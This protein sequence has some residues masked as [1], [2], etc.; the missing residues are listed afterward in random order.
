MCNT[1]ESEGKSEKRPD[2]GQNSNEEKIECDN[3]VIV[4]YYGP[5]ALL[6]GVTP[7]AKEEIERGFYNL[8]RY[9]VSIIEGAGT[10][11]SV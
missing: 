4:E 11:E 7:D 6:K 3:D 10:L 5:I 1:K 2:S 8:Y 9:C